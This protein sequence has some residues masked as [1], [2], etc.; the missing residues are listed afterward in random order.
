MGRQAYFTRLALVSGISQHITAHPDIDSNDARQGRSPFE[1][2]EITAQAAVPVGAQAEP[3][4]NDNG[5][6]QHNSPESY[7]PDHYVQQFDVRGH[8]I[9]PASR[10]STRALIR[11]QNDVLAT[12]GVCVGATDATGLI[13]RREDTKSRERLRATSYENHA[14]L[15]FL[16]TNVIILSLATCGITG[17]RYRLQV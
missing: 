1:E 8:P 4:L 7:T 14:G 6:G 5:G 11:A 2:P 13:P 10:Y 3:H 16:A 17:L 12:V 15:V 9:N